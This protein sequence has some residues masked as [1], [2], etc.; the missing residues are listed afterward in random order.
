MLKGRSK[1]IKKLRD[2]ARGKRCMVNLECCN[3]NPETTVLA[4]VYPKGTKGMGMKGLDIIAT[5][6]CSSCHDVLDGRAKS[7]YS[8]EDLQRIGF[9]S[10]LKTI[11]ALYDDE[12]LNVKGV[13]YLI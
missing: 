7:E 11:E 9:E 6:A 2:Y 13:K 10:A 5:W 12:M 1:T 8:H 3:H 4:H